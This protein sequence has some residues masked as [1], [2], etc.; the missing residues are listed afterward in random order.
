MTQAAISFGLFWLLK[1]WYGL[2]INQKISQGPK[3]YSKL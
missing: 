1:D 2:G 3:N